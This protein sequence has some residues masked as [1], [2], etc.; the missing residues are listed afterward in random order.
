MKEWLKKVGYS[1]TFA[2]AGIYDCLKKQRNLRIDFVVGA[3][4][5]LLSLFLPVST[6][7][8]L[9]IVFSVFIVIVFEMLNSL[10]ESLL[11]LFYPFF[12]EEVKKAKDLAAG[13]V[14]ITAVFAITVGLII[15]GKHLIKT[16]DLI[17]V[18][19]FFLF[20]STFYLWVRKGMNHGKNPGSD[21]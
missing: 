3:A 18:F 1:F 9:W 6:F 10:V 21:L 8:I 19:A 5:L 16:P 20:L 4:V 13:I 17:G 14:L 2:L 12:H 11:D 7:E 15:F